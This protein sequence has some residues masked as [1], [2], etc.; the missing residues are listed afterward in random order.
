MNKKKTLAL[1]FAAVCMLPC[2]TACELLEEESSAAEDV[3]LPEP[4][5]NLKTYEE[6]IH[7]VM[8]Q[9]NDD[10]R[11]EEMQQ[12][13]EEIISMAD[14]SFSAYA[15]AEMDYYADW[16]KDSLLKIKNQAYSNYYTVTEMATW[17]LANGY[18]KS[19]YSKLFAPYVSTEWMSY[20]LVNNLRRVISNAQREAKG[21][22]DNLNDYY[23]IAYKSD[24]TEETDI[25]LQCA[26]LYLDILKDADI[27]DYLYSRYN[28]DYTVQQASDLFFEAKE[29]LLPL[30]TLYYDY[31]ADEDRIKNHAVTDFEYKD[32]YELLETY[33]PKMSSV[34]GE[35]ARKLIDESLYVVPEAEDCYDGSYTIAL[36]NEQ[37]AMMYTHLD[38][39]FY[40]FVDVSH[41]F[42][43]F[44]SDWRDTTPVYS[45][46]NCI[47]LAEVQS[48]GME[49]LFT[50][51][52]PEI[53]GDN[54]EYLELTELYNM[55]DS[56]VSGLAVG[57][58]E[59]E[60]MQR[61]DSITAEEV[62]ELYYDLT[63]GCAMELP[64]NEVTHL[65]EQPGYYVSYGVSALPALYLYTMMLD[66]RDTAMQIY[67][68]LSSLSTMNNQYQFCSAM[69]E[70]GLP[71]IFTDR[72]TDDIAEVLEKRMAELKE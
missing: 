69:E 33:A 18:K 22:F 19:N 7:A 15:R 67:D 9:W 35:S 12:Q 59:Y 56:V 42:G 23:D 58:F 63:E 60:V 37:S 44:H 50:Q 39:S 65:F 54:A 1:F 11:E 28:R 27:S 13:I 41:E 61:L 47:D 72:I 43:H 66:D 64:L 55:I 36:T 51:Y 32:P 8:K 3:V 31:L 24:E 2:L 29:Q 49:I 71:D 34:I 46:V 38:G 6:Q 4:A 25:D 30:Y 52:Y 21:E 57:E 17:F 20:Y 68:Q 14:V 10:D 5:V 53:F 40:D 45:Q 48:Q 62:V 16:S 26:E 70:C